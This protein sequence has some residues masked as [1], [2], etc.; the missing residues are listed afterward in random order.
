MCL[1]KIDPKVK[2]HIKKEKGYG[3]GWKIFIEVNKRREFEVFTHCKKIPLEKWIPEKSFR[4]PMAKHFNY[5][6]GDGLRYKKGFHFYLSQED[7][8]ISGINPLGSGKRV[9]RKIWF[10]KPVAFGYQNMKEVGVAKEI[11]IQRNKK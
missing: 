2:N 4:S 10:K 11:Y 7:A 5:I 8:I 3:I 9:V 6:D 1:H